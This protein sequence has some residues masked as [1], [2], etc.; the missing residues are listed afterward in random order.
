MHVDASVGEILVC[1]GYVGMPRLVTGG[2]YALG[3]G[4]VAYARVLERVELQRVGPLESL[5][6][7]LPAFVKHVRTPPHLPGVEIFGKQIIV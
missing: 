4:K 6:Q 1:G 5:A 2:H 3:V 7:F